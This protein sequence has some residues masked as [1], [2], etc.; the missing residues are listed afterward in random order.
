MR[1]ISGV[2]ETAAGLTSL[3][4]LMTAIAHIPFVARARRRYTAGRQQ[5]QAE[6]VRG[7]VAAEIAPV[8]AEFRPNGGSSLKDRFETHARETSTR[9]GAIE[10]SMLDGGEQLAAM[11]AD[12]THVKTIQ[13][14]LV[15]HLLEELPK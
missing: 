8:L 10:Q 13:A 6:I 5:E 3:A 14:S 11:N 1:G 15:S 7:V 4:A 9:I 12:L 2:W